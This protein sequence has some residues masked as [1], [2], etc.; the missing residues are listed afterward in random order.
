[1]DL[2]GKEVSLN[3]CP[4]LGGN[5]GKQAACLGPSL[6]PNSKLQA[7]ISQVLKVLLTDKVTK[8]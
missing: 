1:M 2:H 6:S 3:F 7:I 8:Y 5:R 4:V